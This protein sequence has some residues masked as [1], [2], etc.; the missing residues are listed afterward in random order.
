[1]S[2]QNTSATGDYGIGIEAAADATLW[3]ANSTDPT[4]AAGGIIFGTSQDTNLYRS[5]ANTLRTDD[6]FS[7]GTNLTVTD[8]ATVSGSGTAL[9]VTNN[10]DF[11]G[12][13]A[14]G[15]TGT[16]VNGA[17]IFLSHTFTS[18]AD[19]VFGCYG[20]YN[21]VSYDGVTNPTIEGAG[22]FK[23]THVSGSAS[24]TYGIFISNTALTAGSITSNY[25]LRVAAQT[26]GTSDY[27]IAVEAADTQTLWVSSEAD[28][29]TAA[30]GIAFGSSRDTNIYRG[31]ANTLKTDD[32]LDIATDSA[33]ALVVETSGGTDVLNINTST[34]GITATQ[35]NTTGTF[36]ALNASATNQTSSSAL[37]VTQ[38]NTTTGYTGNLVSITGTS[39]TGA[40]NILN[41]S[42][43]NTTAGNAVNVTA[44]S[45]T[46][47]DGV[48]IN[49]TGTGLTSGSL[50]KVTTATTGAV[51]TNGAVSFQATGNYT[52]SSNIGLLSVQADSTTAGTVQNI[53]GNALT[54][55][56]GLY[57]ASTGTGLTSGSLLRVTSATTGA[58]ATNGIVSLSAT[59][60]YTSSSNV[61]L[62]N[63][64]ADSTTAGTI[65]NISG[66]ALTTGVGLRVAST[67]TGLTSGSLLVLTS[68]TTGAVATNGIASIQA[69]GNYTS[70]SNVGALSVQANSTTAGTVQN[71]SANALTTGV[72]LHVASTGTGLTS[73]SLLYVT[74]AT[75]GAVAT[76]GIVSLNATGNYTSTSNAG[77]LDVK[78]NATTTGTVVNIQG[79]ALTTGTALNVSSTSVMT[80]TGNIATFT[81]NS[82]TTAT[83][84]VTINATGLTSGAALDINAN[85]S[86]NAITLN[87][88]IQFDTDATR[89]ITVQTQ[90]TVATAGSNLTVSAATGNTSGIGGT[91]TLQGGTGGSSAAGGAVLVT[92]GNAGGGNTNGGNVTISGG[93]GSGT[94]VLGL[95]V[96]TTP[97]YDTSTVQ[98]F[99]GSAAITQANI[100]SKSAILISAN[101][102][103]YT[104]TL[105]DPTTTTAGRVIYVTNSGSYDMTLAVNGGGSGN[106]ITLKPNTTATMIW[107]GSDWTAAGAS[108]STDLQAAYDNTATSAGG[109]ELVLNAPG[110]AADGLTIR[111]ND[112]T[113][114]TGGILE[115]QTSVGSNLFSVNNNATEYANNG[116]AESSTFTMWT[117]ASSGGLE[118][119]AR[120]TTAGTYATGQAA[121]SIV[122]TGVATQGIKNTLSST[123][124]NSLK[125]QVSFAIRASSTAFTALDVMYSYDG[126]TT[127]VRHCVS[128]TA[129]YSTGT[130]SQSGTTITGSGTTFTSAMV[131]KTF[132][133]ANGVSTVISGYTSATQ[134]TAATSQTVS[135]QYFGIYT[136]GYTVNTGIWSR[137]TCTFTA[138][139]SGTTI[140]ASNAVLIRQTDTTTRTFYVDNLSVTASADVNHAVDG[141]V[142]DSTNFATNYTAF[143]ASVT[144]TRDT[145]T[146]YDTSG[147]VSVATPAT[148]DRGVRNNLNIVPSV[149]T[150]Y[151][152]T[153]YGKIA[154][155]TFTDLR[156]RYT[157]DG[158]TNFVSC[159]DYN[160]Q[161]LSTSSWTKITCLLT[162]DSS[163]ATN[164][165][166]VIDQ[167]TAT[168]RTFYIDALTMTLN[169]NNSNNVQ[170]GGANKGGPVTLLTLD[171]SSGPPIATSNDA[172]LGSMYYDTNT[173]RIQCYESDGWGAC[174]AAPDN[175]VNLNPEYSG[176]VL[177][178]TGVGTMTA[179]SCGNGGGLSLNTSLCASGEARNFY[180][181]TSPQ[182]T[183]QTYSIYVTYQL[184]ATFKNFASDDT[185]QLTAR[186]DS[187]SNAAVTY[188]MYKSQSGSITQC[189][190]GETTVVTS[191]DTW[192]T[193]GI[194]GNES[195]SCSFSTSSANAFII[196]KINVK[197]NSNA[198]AYVGTLSF[199]TTGN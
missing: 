149:S 2:A 127:N 15:S 158:G 77:L 156:V 173:G 182:A 146:I 88:N 79:N 189:G 52:S 98:N 61:G 112:T 44:N 8:S 85:T 56:V 179:D 37:S 153:F 174:G 10:A 20:S 100:D 32:A 187:T 194:N 18:S 191:A 16:I 190:S 43:A 143:G 132:V 75:T 115:V 120:T 167:P 82:A 7:I 91:L 157:R 69:T 169:T 183:Q 105:S 135:S 41:V 62:L 96:L 122:T 176:A 22:Y 73:G 108:S 31:A 154:S 199:T 54:T 67:G 19:C 97:T 50:L 170:I 59:G 181:W 1:V 93:T 45:L 13:I 186:T 162:T 92:G 142:D 26:A 55:G 14:V 144:V 49:S 164:A 151:L 117:D 184:P 185:I 141:S 95:V 137:V 65:Q 104:A 109:A 99:T 94:G 63:L 124:T 168:A 177:N 68:A 5:A 172:Y 166:L 118:T 60:N 106:E 86:A 11:G 138:P 71:I 35:A 81:A 136:E 103:G 163:T 39:T 4:T 46:T 175:V 119:T 145:S 114:I 89:T 57:V 58:V 36:F 161:T 74:S 123:L 130:A 110:G 193:V 24:N 47:G 178:G 28:N 51:A 196:F 134:L 76:N 160:T 80:T 21:A 48:D 27:G 9:A 171:R 84:I 152:V 17:G 125:Y 195:T 159:G 78:A 133:F 72:G 87:G 33:T 139:A 42:S 30:A 38:S 113:P 197:A 140:T 165:D 6:S 180:K 131:G 102:A 128:G 34:S 23:T 150:Q 90:D 53:S 83:G 70:T 40:A 12:I 107:N 3:L 147:S 25:G 198:N 188:E 192:Q 116:G 101:A 121:A 66:N 29:T 129:F 111:N 148:A 155:G 64:A 126:S